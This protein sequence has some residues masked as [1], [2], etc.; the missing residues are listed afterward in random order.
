L[1]NEQGQEAWT[2]LSSGKTQ[3]FPFGARI[4]SLPNDSWVHNAQQT[5]QITNMTNPMAMVVDELRAL[6]QSLLSESRNLVLNF[7][8][9]PRPD[10]TAYRVAREMLR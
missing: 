4:V 5:A 1:V 7:A 2:D 6:K 9:D 10:L 3:L 8:N